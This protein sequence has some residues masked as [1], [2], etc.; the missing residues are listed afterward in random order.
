[1]QGDR[2]N[3]LEIKDLHD[4]MV[5]V[6][7]MAAHWYLSA[8]TQPTVFLHLELHS[9]IRLNLPFYNKYVVIFFTIF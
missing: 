2:Y 8:G 5:I 4:L 3:H 7:G 1:M 6:K 9:P